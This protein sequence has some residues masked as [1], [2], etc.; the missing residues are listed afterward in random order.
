MVIP[1]DRVSNLSSV[2]AQPPPPPPPKLAFFS[3]ANLA[4][5]SDILT[6]AFT[7]MTQCELNLL[8]DPKKE[9]WEIW[10]QEMSEDMQDGTAAL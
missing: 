4:V 6:L 2:S 3:S 7:G 5:A 9:H 1:S 10:Q 8:R